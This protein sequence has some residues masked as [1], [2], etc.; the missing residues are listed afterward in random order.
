[1]KTHWIAS[2][3]VG[4]ALC[5]AI[6]VMAAEP[7]DGLDVVKVRKN[8]YMIA[9]AGANIGVQIGPAGIVLVDSGSAGTSE[10]V[11]A[12]LKK[13]SVQSQTASSEPHSQPVQ[14]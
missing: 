12:A 2:A 1:M 6:S 7:E 3:A 11:L 9:G 13:F 4:L 5:A 8:F 10:K 14:H